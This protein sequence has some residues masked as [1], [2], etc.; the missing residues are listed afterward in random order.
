MNKISAE[1]LKSWLVQSNDIAFAIDY[2]QS[3]TAT[4]CFS[5]RELKGF[6]AKGYGYDKASTLFAT[7]FNTFFDTEKLLRRKS[8]KNEYSNMG[9]KLACGTGI[10]SHEK[11]INKLN[12]FKLER[13][14]DIHNSTIYKLTYKGMYLKWKTISTW[15]K[16]MPKKEC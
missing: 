15:Q 2:K 6:N 14:T 16:I 13:I 10:E 8:V 12:G 7:F 4:L 5:N 1:E 9:K 11:L 3:G